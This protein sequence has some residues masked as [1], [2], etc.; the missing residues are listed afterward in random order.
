MRLCGEAGASL[1]PATGDFADCNETIIHFF[2]AKTMSDTQICFF[3]CPNTLVEG[4]SEHDSCFKRTKPE[5]GRL[6]LSS[7]RS[8]QTGKRFT[9]ESKGEGI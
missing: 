6:F 3:E 7:L 5:G 4:I 2:S 8:P 1:C 9:I